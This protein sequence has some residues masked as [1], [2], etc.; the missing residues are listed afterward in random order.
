[1]KSLARVGWHLL[2]PAQLFARLEESE[3]WN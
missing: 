3:R 1:L 2:T